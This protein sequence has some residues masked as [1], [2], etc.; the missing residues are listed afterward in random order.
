MAVGQDKH[1]DA[2]GFCRESKE[3]GKIASE[4]NEPRQVY[5]GHYHAGSATQ[6]TQKC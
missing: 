1:A 2:D 4:S 3:L 5:F 6:I